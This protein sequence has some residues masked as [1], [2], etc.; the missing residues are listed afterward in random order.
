MALHEDSALLGVPGDGGT[1]GLPKGEAF[2]FEREAGDDWRL[3]SRFAPD[4]LLDGD[5]FGIAVDLNEQWAIVSAYGGSA[6]GFD[7]GAVY[8]FRATGEQWQQFARLTPSEVVNSNKFGSSISLQGDRLLVG[9]PLQTASGLFPG[10]AYLFEFDGTSWNEVH[11]LSP[12]VPEDGQRFG[13]TVHLDQDRAIVGSRVYSGSATQAGAAYVFDFDGST[14]SEVARLEP[15]DLDEYDLFG[16]PVVVDADRIIVGSA[17]ADEPTNSGAAY[18]FEFDGAQWNETRILKAGKPVQDA[19]FGTAIELLGNRAFIRTAAGEL[20]VFD[21]VDPDWQEV[22]VITGVD[23]ANFQEPGSTIAL[24]GGVLL[25]G[26]PLDRQRGSAAGAAYVFEL[27]AGNY[28]QAAKLVAS[29]KPE[30]DLFGCALAV[31]GERAIVGACNDSDVKR[32]AGSATFFQLRDGDWEE[33]AIVAPAQLSE[34]ALFGF[35]VDID[36]DRAI[37]SAFEEQKVYVYNFT[38]SDWVLETELVAGDDA[39]GRFGRSIAISG[40]RIIV[41][42]DYDSD[43]GP[44]AGAAYLFE[45]MESTWIQT[46]KLIATDAQPQ[47]RFGDSVDLEGDDAV[48][49]AF[50]DDDVAVSGGAAYFFA[51]DGIEFV[52]SAKVYAS[53]AEDFDWFGSSVAISGDRA[54]ISSP[55]DDDF[56]PETGAA[57]VFERQSGLWIETDK[58]LPTDGVQGEFGQSIDLDGDIAAIGS[59]I[60]RTGYIFQRTQDGWL[61][62]NEARPP[63]VQPDDFFGDATATTA[64]YVMFGAKESDLDGDRAGAVYFLDLEAIFRDGFEPEN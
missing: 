49:G 9:A 17:G 3:A 22:Q 44:L 13:D 39:G 29:D 51:H 62:R 23:S 48:I 8:V 33:V 11:K 34:G 7:A 21:W 4:D 12:A 27:I 18:V 46:Q 54:L 5:T 25:L 50:L 47:G 42:A 37:V 64:R 45:R 61:G 28:A 19:L 60:A 55:L 57:Y 40:D 38:G 15:S 1:P 20:H 16:R 41:G 53:D 14:W 36:E 63:D 2:L 26:A 58:L 59:R 24:D 56:G 52:E 43:A 6:G 31:S 35:A 30:L 10:A 32:N